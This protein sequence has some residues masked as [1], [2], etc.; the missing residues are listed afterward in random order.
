ML[1][2]QSC[3]VCGEVWCCELEDQEVS[4][5]LSSHPE[6][7]VSEVRLPQTLCDACELRYEDELAEVRA[8]D[9]ELDRAWEEYYTY[10]SVEDESDA[11]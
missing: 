9:A 2:D 11:G 4:D 6:L 10:L 1:V 3:H 5:V 7:D 8:E